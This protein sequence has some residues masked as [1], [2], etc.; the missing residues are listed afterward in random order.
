MAIT[1]A[2]IATGNSR[3]SGVDLEVPSGAGTVSV[4]AGQLVCVSVGRYSGSSDPIIVGDLTHS[5]TATMGTWSLDRADTGLTDGSN[6]SSTAVFSSICSS[7]GT[8]HISFAGAPADSY[9]TGAI[10]AYDGSWDSSRLEAGNGVIQTSSSTALDTGNATSAGAALFVAVTQVNTGL[11][12]LTKDAAFTVIYQ[13]IATDTGSSI[14]RI[15]SS[16]TTDSGSWTADT[17]AFYGATVVVYKEVGGG[18]G[19]STAWLIA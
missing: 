4:T 15:V 7:S 16:G 14:Y 9:W 19:V 1:A 8:L 10:E 11:S 5:G 17:A 3:A 2:G 12:S 13:D 6:Y 18:G